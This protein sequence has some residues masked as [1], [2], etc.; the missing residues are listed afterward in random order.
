MAPL[1]DKDFEAVE[2]F[3][4]VESSGL[5]FSTL[6][7]DSRF[8]IFAVTDDSLDSWEEDKVMW[9]TLPAV[10]DSGILPEVTQKL[11]T[12]EI[13][14]GASATTSIKMESS[15]LS[16]YLREDAN[17]IAT[18]LVVRETGEYESQ[19]LV[20]AFATKEHPTAKAPTLYF[21]LR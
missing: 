1:G 11:G 3:L 14:R 6:I 5:G 20:H 18:F 17:R 21:K 2:L 19:G 8:A 10:D 9:D 12:F 4:D 16:T 15:E 13:L 7:P